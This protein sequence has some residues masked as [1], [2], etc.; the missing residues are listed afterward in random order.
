MTISDEWGKL[1]FLIEIVMFGEHSFWGAL[2][3]GSTLS[4]EHF[5]GSS[6][7]GVTALFTGSESGSVGW[8]ALTVCATAGWD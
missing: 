6:L 3:L 2:F 4:G 7:S 8:E 1:S 5:L